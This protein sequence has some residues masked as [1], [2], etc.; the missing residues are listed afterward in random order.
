MVL[1]NNLWISKQKKMKAIVCTKYGP[2]EVLQLKEVEK[3]VPEDNEILL[4]VH[5][6]TVT[7]G[8]CRI[9]SFTWASW[10]WLPGRIMFGL[11]KPRK[12]IPG[13][14]LSGVIESVGKDV[15]LF[16]KGDHIFGYTKG[17]LFNACNA[18]YKCLP[19]DGLIAIKPINMTHEEATAVPI[20]GLTALHFLRKGNIKSG[21][22]VLIYGAS[23]S[24]G[25]FA[26]QL[27][28]YYGAVVTGVC[29]TTN[30]KLVKSLK[31]D[32]VIDY[33]KEDFTK[34]GQTYDIIFDT[35]GKTSFSHCK[36]SL[37]QRGNYL[38]VEWPFLHALW[39]SIIC[40]KKL[41]IGVAPN[42]TEDIIFLKELCETGKL[43]SV[44]DKT[45]PLEQTVE[46]HR[47]VDKGHK[48]GNVVITVGHNNN[49]NSNK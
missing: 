12:N 5:A 45:Y 22:K 28:K 24:V 29:S 43:K 34:N 21:Q 13:C 38:T 17:V 41:I 1:P 23:G 40:S 8:D 35:V 6:S 2:P 42:R 27:A 11:K 30:L 3:P 25:T 46:A 10:F 37:K 36:S 47:Y 18:E 33:T 15:K 7:A 16:W 44:I 19:E 14:D 48:K 20:G 26:V 4:K 39:S 32:K 9:R 31:A 49:F